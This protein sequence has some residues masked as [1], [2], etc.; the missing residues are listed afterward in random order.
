[1]DTIKTGRLL[2]LYQ[3][4][5]RRWPSVFELWYGTYIYSGI[6]S[7]RFSWRPPWMV[8]QQ[9]RWKMKKMQPRRD[10]LDE[11][12]FENLWVS[13]RVSHHSKVSGPLEFICCSAC[14]ME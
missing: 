11:F 13:H 7:F 14:D 12:L 10:Q 6:A 1:M 5:C 8:C 3:P 4:A 9:G 2:I